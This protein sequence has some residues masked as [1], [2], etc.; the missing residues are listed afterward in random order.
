VEFHF[1]GHSRPGN[2][3]HQ[4]ADTAQLA[5]LGFATSTSVKQGIAAY[6]RWLRE[7]AS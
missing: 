5:S 4:Q 1:D 6:A 2:P 3:P 7:M